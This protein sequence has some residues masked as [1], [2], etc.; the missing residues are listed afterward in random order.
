MKTTLLLFLLCTIVQAQEVMDGIAARVNDDLI[1]YSEVRAQTDPKEKK[2]R[3]TLK[4]MA[5][6]NAVKKLRASQI[7][8]M[9]DRLLLRQEL[10]RR[11]VALPGPVTD[12]QIDAAIKDR[13]SSDRVEW[14]RRLK[15]KAV[16]ETY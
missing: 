5:L 10:K 6:V 11:G 4:G 2:L 16:I 7:K 9:I 8:A 15:A 13:F 1:L 3:E 14:L 12:D